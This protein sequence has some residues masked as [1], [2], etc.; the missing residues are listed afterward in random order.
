MLGVSL[1]SDLVQIQHTVTS[2]ASF[3]CRDAEF[4][5]LPCELT[6]EQRTVYDDAVS[7]WQDLRMGLA[8]ALVKT[9]T[10]SRELWKPFWSAQQRFFK[11]LCVSMKAGYSTAAKLCTTKQSLQCIAAV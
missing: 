6:L 10:T 7:L 2:W 9:N 1:R 4:I 8:A 5:E 3:H 11:L